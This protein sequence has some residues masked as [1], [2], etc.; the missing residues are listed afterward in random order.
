M[1][2]NE[3]TE[4]NANDA[5]AAPVDGYVMRKFEF[6]WK[7]TIHKKLELSEN[8][9]EGVEVWYETVDVM[10][11]VVR[12]DGR[13]AIEWEDAAANTFLDTDDGIN[14]LKECKPF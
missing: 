3:S 2:T 8:E 9:M 6:R 10:G 1:M 4:I 14:V 11:K 5:V 12:V 13:L 7:E